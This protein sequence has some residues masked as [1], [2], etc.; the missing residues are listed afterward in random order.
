MYVDQRV[1]GVFRETMSMLRIR[2]AAESEISFAVAGV[3]KIT[4]RGAQHRR[5]AVPRASLHHTRQAAG[6][7]ACGVLLRARLE[8]VGVPPILAELP[9]VSTGIQQ[10]I[11]AGAGRPDSDCVVP[12]LTPVAAEHSALGT[13][14]LASPGPHAAVGSACRLLPFRLG[15]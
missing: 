15:R 4:T 12:F 13:R 11:R 7:W 8:V 9:H 5:A 3:G 2:S 6:S 10:T 14:R 1:M